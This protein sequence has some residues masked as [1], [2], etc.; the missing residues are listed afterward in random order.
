MCGQHL[1]FRG[2]DPQSDR[3]GEAMDTVD[4]VL[5]GLVAVTKYG[6]IVGVRKVRQRTRSTELDTG[7]T[8]HGI[9]EY[10]VNRE[11]EQCR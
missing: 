1:G 5:Y 10:P 6:D 8:R 3:I 11:V 7:N 4:H 2:V 9:P